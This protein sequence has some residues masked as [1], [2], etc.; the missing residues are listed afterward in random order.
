[1]QLVYVR[2]HVKFTP[3][4]LL[5]ITE[6]A[7]SLCLSSSERRR[8]KLFHFHFQ[9]FK[10][11]FNFIPHC[12]HCHISLKQK[13]LDEQT[14]WS[15]LQKDFRMGVELINGP[16]QSITWNP[17]RI[18]YRREFHKSTFINHYGSHYRYHHQFRNVRLMGKEQ[19]R[20]LTKALL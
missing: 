11:C 15:L 17:L 16:F 7:N 19:E 12:P 8:P 20:F 2:P 14:C 18:K 10:S 13:C 5:I 3:L 9:F 1:M 6:I 4:L